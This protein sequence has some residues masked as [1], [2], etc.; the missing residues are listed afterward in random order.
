MHDVPYFDRFAAPYEL[1]MPPAD[2]ETIREAFAHATRPVERVLDVGGGTGR[3]ARSLREEVIVVDASRGML[4]RAREHAL[5]AVR[6]AAERLPVADR[7][8]DA[9]LIVDALHHFEDQRAALAEAARVLRP[10]GVAVVREFDPTT[11]R[12]R[13]LAAGERLLGMRSTFLPPDAVVD[14]LAVDGLYA[15]VPDRGFTYTAVGVRPKSGH[16]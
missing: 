3:V 7:S 5:P 13:A 14:A 11:I 6:A 16:T 9:V 8:V 15:D 2:V 10:G 1:L 12:G 4:R